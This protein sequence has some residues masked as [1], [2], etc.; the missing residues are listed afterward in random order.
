MVSDPFDLMAAWR[1]ES[2]RRIPFVGDVWD[3][4]AC[5]DVVSQLRSGQ[6]DALRSAVE[7]LGSARRLHRF[8][9]P[10]ALADLASLVS[11]LPDEVATRVDSLEMAT[12]LAVAWTADAPDKATGLVDPLSQ[13]P[14][15]EYL[16]LRAA[17]IYEEA[18]QLHVGAP[19]RT[20]VLVSVID[21]SSIVERLASCIRVGREVG[22]AFT[23]LPRAME[24]G[25]AAVI[26]PEGF[27]I[28][29][30]CR[31]IIGVA[32]VQVRQVALPRDAQSL[33]T[34]LDALVGEYLRP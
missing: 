24:D 11:V 15:F 26:V 10:E 5:S 31:P 20:L 9:L 8:S 19:R 18:A 13:Q 25:L 23:G 3:D 27:D 7:A 4:P 12:A 34:M 32:R 2:L 1:A 28:D 16:R 29:A 6:V 14:T 33:T 17:E 22:R 30:A 21:D